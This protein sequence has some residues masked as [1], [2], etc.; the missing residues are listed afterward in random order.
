MYTILL[1]YFCSHTSNIL[2]FMEN[3]SALHS[4]VTGTD[5]AVHNSA[6]TDGN[7]SHYGLNTDSIATK[8][9]FLVYYKKVSYVEE[10]SFRV[11]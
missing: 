4:A 1:S 8:D 2:D 11:I 5:P 9:A 10:W 3:K 6:N 7:S